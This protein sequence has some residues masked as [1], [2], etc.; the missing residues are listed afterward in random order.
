MTNYYENC[1]DCGIHKRVYGRAGFRRCATCN[2][3]YQDLR[4]CQC[5]CGELTHNSFVSGHNIREN[6]KEEQQRRGLF[7]RLKDWSFRTAKPSTYRKKDGKHIHRQQAEEKLGRKL[8]SGEIVHHMDGNRHNNDSGNIE[9]LANQAE[10]AR[11]HG[12]GMA[13]KILSSRGDKNATG[14]GSSGAI[15]R[16][17]IGE[18]EPRLSGPEDPQSSYVNQ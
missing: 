4:P 1:L 6:S 12:F 13:T 15:S 18:N 17:G 7:N 16:S 9:V 11:I 5:G 8:T 3:A 2:K 14:A 10:H